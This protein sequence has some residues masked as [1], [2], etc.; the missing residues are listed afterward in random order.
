MEKGASKKQKKCL[1]MCEG[2]H[3]RRARCRNGTSTSGQDFLSMR[4]MC[5]CLVI[6][7]IPSGY[8]ICA[9]GKLNLG[10]AVGNMNKELSLM[11]ETDIKLDDH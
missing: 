3:V 5:V 11:W 8:L 1:Q 7:K 6:G 4:P 9:G 2:C 10:G